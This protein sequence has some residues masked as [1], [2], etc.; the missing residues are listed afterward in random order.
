MLVKVCVKDSFPSDLLFV[1]E[2]YLNNLNRN[3]GPTFMDISTDN[4]FYE[5]WPSMDE[6]FVGLCNPWL[7][8]LV[9]PIRHRRWSEKMSRH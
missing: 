5:S 2:G 9:F 8:S 7:R 3:D 4:I 1:K 6:Y